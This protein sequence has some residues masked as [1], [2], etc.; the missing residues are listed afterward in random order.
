MWTTACSAQRLQNPRNFPQPPSMAVHNDF[1][2]ENP[3]Q[4]SLKAG[5]PRIDA[6]LMNNTKRR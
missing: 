1:Q 2:P 3:R 4:D 5:Y 6:F